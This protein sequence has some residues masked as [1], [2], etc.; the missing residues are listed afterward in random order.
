VQPRV[1]PGG[2]GGRD[3]ALAVAERHLVVGTRVHAQHGGPHRHG[4][5]R[6]GVAVLLGQVAGTAAHQVQRRGAADGVAGAVGERQHAS[7]RDNRGHRDPRSRR[8]GH[9]FRGSRPAGRPGGEVTAGAVPDDHDAIGV[10]GEVREQVD[11]RG[12]IG[13]RGRPAATATGAPVLK[14]PYG[15]AAPGQVGRERPAER[16]VVA[17]APETA[18]HDHHGP[19]RSR[20][21]GQPQLSVLRWIRTITMHIRHDQN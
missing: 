16:Q 4:G 5:H 18:V 15:V 2:R 19:A 11:P 8:T 17:G 14:V 12:D 20:A 7:L 10:D 9:A 21:G 13:E 1:A 6:V 3:V